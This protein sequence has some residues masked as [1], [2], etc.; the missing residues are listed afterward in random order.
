MIPLVFNLQN[1]ETL[2]HKCVG[3]L[4]VVIV[5]VGS[6][7]GDGGSGGDVGVDG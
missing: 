6:S 3:M 5:C 7:S 4:M 1:D 2:S